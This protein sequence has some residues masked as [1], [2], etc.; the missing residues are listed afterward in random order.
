MTDDKEERRTF[1]GWTRD[2]FEDGLDWNELA[3][4]KWSDLVLAPKHTDAEYA[5]L[6]AALWREWHYESYLEIHIEHLK[7]RIKEL[8]PVGD[9]EQTIREIH[10]YYSDSGSA[11]IGA[12]VIV[13]T[14]EH[15]F[16]W[17]AKE[18]KQ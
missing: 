9:P 18:R 10:H 4:C 17:L 16:P 6:E 1:L 2:D 13:R 15:F 11:E 12:E 8:E 7:A 14:M 5:T 3:H